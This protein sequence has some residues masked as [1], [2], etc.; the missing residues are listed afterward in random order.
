MMQ[1]DYI[2]A[3]SCMK[4]SKLFY[5][6]SDKHRFPPSF[7]AQKIIGSSTTLKYRQSIIRY[8]VENDIKRKNNNQIVTEKL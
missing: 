6:D 4:H 2:L 7:I 1:A 5:H 3:C 8:L